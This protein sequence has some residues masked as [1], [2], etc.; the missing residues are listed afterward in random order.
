MHVTYTPPTH[1]LARSARLFLP[2]IPPILKQTF[3]LAQRQ[4]TRRCY[5]TE[6]N[7]THQ[8]KRAAFADKTASK[9][10]THR[11]TLY[12]NQRNDM[13]VYVT[14]PWHARVVVVH[15]VVVAR[16]A[17]FGSRM[18]IL[19]ERATYP[20]HIA[21]YTVYYTTPTWATYHYLGVC[22]HST[23]STEYEYVLIY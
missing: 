17:R 21:K 19:W 5:G 11:D 13:S 1:Y 18:W 7:H 6:D 12:D 22:V 15:I 4:R 16:R 23:C 8:T 14:I 3:A 9:S 20:T 2:S 10:P